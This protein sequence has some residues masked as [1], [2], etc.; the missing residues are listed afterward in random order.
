MPRVWVF[1]CGTDYRRRIQPDVLSKISGYYD[2]L[3]RHDVTFCYYCG[4]FHPTAF[5]LPPEFSVSIVDLFFSLLD[6]T[7]YISSS[8]DLVMLT[9][10]CG[11][12]IVP[13]DFI[14]HHLIPPVLSF[15]LEHAPLPL[16]WTSYHNGFLKFSSYLSSLVYDCYVPLD[17]L[18]RA[19]SYRS[20]IRLFHN[21]RR[22]RSYRHNRF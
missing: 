13:E 7:V 15:P 18:S 17:I 22:T 1:V 9:K 4:A 20:F 5:C 3:E 8:C 10:L 6:C 14:F 16:I 21:Y 2:A 19:T 12:L 11:F